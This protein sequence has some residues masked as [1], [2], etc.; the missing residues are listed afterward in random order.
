VKSII[1]RLR[2]LENVAAPALGEQAA[3]Q[4]ILEARRR[5]LGLDYV[6]PP[7]LPA[8]MLHACRTTAERIIAARCWYRE[9]NRVKRKEHF[10]AE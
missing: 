1:S 10:G 2:R 6:E 3:V 4:A 7:P 9:Q 5:R 8:D